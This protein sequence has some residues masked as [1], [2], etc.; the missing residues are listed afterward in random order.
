MKEKILCYNTNLER[1]DSYRINIRNICYKLI[2]LWIQNSFQVAGG[3]AKYDIAKLEKIITVKFANHS[4]TELYI[5]NYRHTLLRKN[6]TG[7]HATGS[8]F[9]TKNVSTLSWL[10]QGF[11]LYY[12]RSLYQNVVKFI[13]DSWLQQHSRLINSFLFKYCSSPALGC[14]FTWPW[15]SFI[16]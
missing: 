11:I 5:Q 9:I 4:H 16:G 6:S 14:N 13:I 3:L 15:V 10:Q 8:F 7:I 2:I 1:S 12:S